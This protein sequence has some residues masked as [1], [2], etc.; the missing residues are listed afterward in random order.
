MVTDSQPSFLNF[1]ACCLKIRGV[2][3][4]GSVPSII[5]DDG[6]VIGIDPPTAVELLGDIRNYYADP[7]LKRSRDF[8]SY[9]N[10]SYRKKMSILKPLLYSRYIRNALP[11]VDTIFPYSMP[12]IRKFRTRPIKVE[13]APEGYDEENK[14]YSLERVPLE[15]CPLPKA[16]E[17]LVRYFEEV[18]FM[19]L[20]VDEKIGERLFLRRCVGAM[21]TIFCH[22]LLKCQKPGFLIIG[23]DVGT[24]KT[25]LARLIVQPFMR[26]FSTDLFGSD[27][28]VH[29]VLRSHSLVGKKIIIFDNV[30]KKISGQA[31][32]EA[33]TS[34]FIRVK[35][36][37]TEN[38][39]E[40]R[41]DF[42][43]VFTGN[44]CSVSPDMA[45]RL[46]PVSLFERYV[47]GKKKYKRII[48]QEYFGRVRRYIFSALWAFITNWW[49]K[50]RPKAKETFSDFPQ[51]NNLICGIME[52]ADWPCIFRP[53]EE[54]DIDF[55]FYD[56]LKLLREID[57]RGLLKKELSIRE[58]IQI[59]LA[60][61]LFTFQLS[62]CG[63]DGD[64]IYVS[65]Y[66]LE[67]MKAAL[68]RFIGRKYN[69]RFLFRSL[70]GMKYVVEDLKNG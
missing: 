70:G 13:M 66:S 64:N 62:H 50:G 27:Q 17:I 53:I 18:P 57:K 37:R 7:P 41:S 6:S 59:S 35:R 34:E 39:V 4:V 29:K 10:A 31:I 3:C 1:L 54:F 58:I 48:D 19:T 40:V 36:W 32:E 26:D 30:S 63:M 28:D 55:V 16:K 33:M 46:I 65:P 11:V 47:G 51:W 14:L 52:A 24:G 45:R 25:T 38:F 22:N 9:V 60:E 61:G 8:I 12:V 23:N 49:K 43:F 15:N 21:L 44:K 67:K 5:R 56:F 20:G 42:V 69:D 68:G 2:K